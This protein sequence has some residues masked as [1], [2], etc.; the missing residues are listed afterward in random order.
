MHLLDF[1]YPKTCHLCGQSLSR[2]EQYICTAC[3]SHLPR[4]LYHRNPDNA[5]ANRF[6]GLFPFERASGHFF[7]SSNSVL[8]I[9]MQDLKYRHFRGLARYMGELTASELLM[10]GFLSDIDYI[11]PVPM[12]YMKQ[13]RR[14]Y[15]QTE[16]IAIGISKIAGIPICCDL[17]AIRSHRT[18]TSLTLQQRQANTTGIFQLKDSSKVAGNHILLLDDVCTTG[19]TLT[20][21]AQAM[22]S[23]SPTT[24][25]SLLTLGVTF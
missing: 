24:R 14:G 8:S 6:S 5:L 16:Q 19:S 15:N 22:L 2:S 9:L 11:V 7:Y 25:L 20:S 21:A 1:I 4:T 3:V 17:K 18:Q 23:T 12:H 13:A 10:T